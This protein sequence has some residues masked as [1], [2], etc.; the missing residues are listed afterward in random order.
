MKDW[1]HPL[2]DSVFTT[3]KDSKDPRLGDY[4]TTAEEADF[5]IWGYPDD[6]GIRLNQGRPGA[7][8]APRKI[9]EILYKLTPP[10]N[11]HRFWKISDLGDLKINGTLAERHLRARSLSQ[12]S[13]LQKKWISLGGGHDYAFAD[14]AGFCDTLLSK[15]LR[16]LVVNI[17]AHLDV[18]PLDR[19]LTSGTSFFRLLEEYAG[20]IDFVEIGIQNHCNS[21]FHYKY[22]LEK[23]A[24]VILLDEIRSQGMTSSLQKYFSAHHLQPTFLSLDIDACSSM[25]APGCSQSWTEGLNWNELNETLRYIIK[26]NQLTAMGIYEVSPPLDQGLQTQRLAALLAY[27]WMELA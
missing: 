10:V 12:Q 9:R 11:S 21:R 2:P 18:R 17:D 19:G 20:K 27:Q 25:L 15:G 5:L 6:E 22:A 13:T 23:G 3:R 7:A 8:E 1:L 4:L 24:K 14:A 26:N 16:P